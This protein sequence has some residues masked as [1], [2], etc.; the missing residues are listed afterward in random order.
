MATVYSVC[1]TPLP[2]SEVTKLLQDPPEEGISS[3]PPVKAK[4][5]EIYLYKPRGDLH[6]GKSN[7]N[8]TFS[9]VSEVGR[10]GDSSQHLISHAQCSQPVSQR[11]R[12]RFR[13]GPWNSVVFR[14]VPFREIVSPAA[15]AECACVPL[16]TVYVLSCRTNIQ[17]QF[18][19][20]VACAFSLIIHCNCMRL[21]PH[22][23]MNE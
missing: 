1:T 20:Q 22:N 9:L 8:K 11:S 2:I 3:L 10:I 4:A 6:K 23:I 13:S 19:F 18:D 21:N 17:L 14:S 16:S 12:P 5:G 15:C 7:N